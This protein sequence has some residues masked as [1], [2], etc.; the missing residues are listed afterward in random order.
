MEIKHANGL[1]HEPGNIPVE[2]PPLPNT[3]EPEPIHRPEPEPVH[4]PEPEPGPN[5]IPLGPGTIPPEPRW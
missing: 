5:E 1:E 3:K 4:N 2:S